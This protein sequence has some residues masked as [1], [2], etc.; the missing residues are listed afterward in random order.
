MTQAVNARRDGD[1]FQ[2][3]MFWLKAVHLLDPAGCIVRVGFES[4]PGGYDDIWVE[5]D[6]PILDQHGNPLRREH[7]QCK[8]HVTPDSY[9]H[10]H[11]IDPEFINANRRTLLERART[12][13]EG[14]GDQD[15]GT[16]FR[17]VT[18][19][20]IDRADPLRRL[21]NE[22]SHTLRVDVLYGTTTARSEMGRVRKLWSEHLGLG[23]DALRSLVGL[24][25]FSESGDSLDGLRERLDPY[26]GQFGLR[27]VPMGQSAFIYDDVVFQWAAQGRLEFTRTSFRG[28]CEREGLTAEPGTG[29]PRIYGVKSFEHPT[30]KLE[31][32]CTKVLNLVPNFNDRQ[33]RPESDW[34]DDIYGRLKSFLLD[35]ARDGER[36]R[37]VLDA[38][39][40]LSFAA[41]SILNIKSG[42]MIELEQRT[43]GKAIWSP[44]DKPV[45]PAWPS[46]MD[47]DG[48]DEGVVG[49]IVVAVSLTHDIADAVRRFVAESIPGVARFIDARLSVSPGA[50][51]V[52]SGRHAFDLAEA[53]ASRMKRARET[54]GKGARVHLFIAAPGA[55]SF[56]LGQRQPSIGRVVLYEYDFEGRHGGSYEKSLALPFVAHKPTENGLTA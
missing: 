32:R 9:G 5:Y 3:R 41:G 40:T 13:R 12:A 4:G 49:D 2:A 1:T 47:N 20:R 54:A 17:L 33:I 42:R 11:L 22:R 55:F 38:H 56:F 46:W 26:L 44:D 19:W 34:Q 24:L 43:I 37:L 53:L 50:R 35:A 45:D 36:L 8:W 6:P 31:D 7:I 10:T 25:A 28:H 39:L 16:R 18:N 29:R 52:A 23:E 48:S 21:V 14:Y 15:A 30:D 27:R 51:S